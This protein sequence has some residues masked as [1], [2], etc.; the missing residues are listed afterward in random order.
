MKRIWSIVISLAMLAVLFVGCTQAD[1]T[2]I[3][4]TTK[5]TTATTAATTA[6]PTDPEPTDPT[7]PETPTITWMM[8]QMGGL[9]YENDLK[10]YEW[11]GEAGNLV[12][13]PVP[14]PIDV[15]MDKL[16]ILVAGNDLPDIVNVGNQDLFIEAFQPDFALVMEI[17]PKGLLASLSDNMDKLPHYELWL[18]KFAPYVGGITS[19]DG[20]IYFASTIRNYNPTSSLGGVIRSDLADTMTF[21]TFDDLYNTLKAMRDNADGPIWTNRSGILNLNLLSYSFGTS[22]TDFPYYDQYAQAFI[23]PVATQNFKDS[24]L[25]FKSLVDA[26]ILTREWAT[27]P[28]PDWYADGK[29]GLCQF[30]VDNMMNAPTFN[31]ALPLNGISGQF[32]AFVPPSYNGTFYG[33]AGKSRLSTTG[34]VIS[35]KTAALDNILAMMDWTYNEAASHDLIYWGEPGITCKQLASGGYGNTSPGAQTTD[36]FVKLVNEIYGI[37]GNSNFQKVFNNAEYYN[38]RH[39]DGARTWAP[40][41]KVYG[42]YVYTYSV[43]SINLNEESTELFKEIYTPLQTYIMENVTNF[44]NGVTDMS[45]FDAFVAQV[46][47]MG[48][49][50]LVDLYNNG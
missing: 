29:A 34:S 37:G 47:S 42:D 23:N 26:D 14:V 40:F 22:L 11:L 1:P 12:I 19:S 9:V 45:E 2:T 43:P 50:T 5:P 7:E 8:R 36:V 20:K 10:I 35:A 33:W 6:K 44:I 24:I 49:Q 27:Y 3:E 28:E 38:D 39:F 16:S 18:E 4:P 21:E 31:T 13:E 15:Y 32:E 46:E 30:W 17:G 25:F 41:G 48:G